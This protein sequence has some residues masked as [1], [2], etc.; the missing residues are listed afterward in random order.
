MTTKLTTLVLGTL[1]L[2]STAL[3]EHK[4]DG[5]PCEMKDGKPCPMMLDKNAKPMEHGMAGHHMMDMS[6]KGD[7]S[8]SSQAYQASNM[9]M[10]EGMNIVFTGDADIDFLR[11]MIPHHQGAVEMARIQL[12]YG[13]HPQLKRITRD[14]IRA[15][16]LE[17]RQMTTLLKQLEAN[18]A[19]FHDSKWMGNHKGDM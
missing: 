13:S 11:G 17:I 9:S 1:L 10:H 3:A 16:E 19:G 5:K 8:A 7:T 15:Q 14:I 18:K 12:K 2:A 4:G 6:M